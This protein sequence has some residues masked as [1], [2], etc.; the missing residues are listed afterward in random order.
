MDLLDTIKEIVRPPNLIIEGDQ[1]IGYS[2]WG[3][4]DEATRCL[5]GVWFV[6][7]ASHGGFWL[8]EDRISQLPES[9][10]ETNFLKSSTGA[11]WWEE[12][13]DA[14]KVAEFFDIT[15]AKFGYLN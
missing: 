6:S 12:D 10:K 4:I 3:K 2:P 11:I 1:V 8:S 14:D 7:T 9:I 13:C 5:E 15:A